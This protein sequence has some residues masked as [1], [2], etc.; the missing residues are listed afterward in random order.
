MGVDSALTVERPVE[1][2]RFEA[3]PTPAALAPTPA[4]VTPA[5]ISA[6]NINSF[7]D[8]NV[9]Y[10]VGNKARLELINVNIVDTLFDG[11][12]QTYCR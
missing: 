6:D 2:S 11:W 4:E 1:R 3:A 5:Q 9:S 12:I 10:S 8:N 7:S